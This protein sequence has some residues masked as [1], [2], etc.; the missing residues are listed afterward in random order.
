MN[1]Q[2]IT[3]PEEDLPEIKDWKDGEEYIVAMKLKQISEGKFEILAA[4]PMEMSDQESK[5]DVESESEGEPRQMN[6]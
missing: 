1:N 6:M 4:H 3:I 2:E 5:M